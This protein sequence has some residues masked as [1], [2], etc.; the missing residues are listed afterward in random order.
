MFS[1]YILDHLLMLKFYDFTQEKIILKRSAH[2][3]EEYVG[4]NVRAKGLTGTKNKSHIQKKYGHICTPF[5][6]QY[7]CQ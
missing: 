3:T 1:I 7:S 2:V 5:L 6:L 4:S